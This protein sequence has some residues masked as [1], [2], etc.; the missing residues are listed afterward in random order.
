M[1]ERSRRERHRN[2]RE[3]IR[4]TTRFDGVP[5]RKVIA[6]LLTLGALLALLVALEQETRLTGH[7]WR[8]TAE[9]R[10]SR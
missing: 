2:V 5:T 3:S 7:R 10:R 4:D 6:V 8:P 1:L 9:R